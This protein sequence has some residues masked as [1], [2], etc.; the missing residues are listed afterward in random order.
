MMQS[1][2]SK[3]GVSSLSLAISFALA[4]TAISTQAFA[5]DD[6][7]AVKENVEKIAVVGSRAA[8][9][10]IGDSPV[11][12]DII[13]S[14]DLK[15]NGSTDMI[16]MLVTSVPSFNSRAQPISDAATLVR[17]VNLRGLPSDSTLILVNGKRRHRASVIAFQGGGINDGAQGPDI[18]VIPGVALKQ[19]EVL[20]D[21][22][23]AQYGSD[24]IAGVMNF[25]LK[26]D[27]D[28]GS[29]T[30]SQ[31]EYYEGDGA[32]TTI[33]GNIGLPLS[34]DGFVNIS[35]QYKTADATSRSVQRPD[36]AAL[37]AAGNEFIQDP[38]QTWGNPEIND[39]FTV[40]VNSGYDLNDNTKLYAFGNVSS[41][42]A[43]G[44][45]YYR[46]PHNRGNVYSNDGG[47]T[48]LV[49]DV[50]LAENGVASCSW[51]GNVP[52]N[53]DNVLDTPE[54]LAMVA[55]PNCFSMNQIRPGGYT[56]QFTGKIE[57]MSFFAGIKGESG[58]WMYDVS[59]GTGSNKASF[60]LKNSLNPSLGL[61]TPTDF[62]TGSYEQVET[63]FNV[64]MNR[65]V[66]IGGLED[67][68]FA[69]GFEWRE[70]SFEIG[71][72]DEASWIAG[73]YAEQGFNIGSHGFKGFG[74][75]SAGKN[76]RNN[77]GVYTDVEAY[78]TDEFLLGFALRYENFS[79]F[80][81]TLNYKLTA[82][83]MATDELSFRA[84]H[85]TGFRAPTVGQENVVNTQTSIVNGDLIQSFIAPPTD[86][87]AAF[88]GGETLNPEESVSYAA[89]FVYEYENLFLTVDYYNIEVT[90]R[91]AQSSQITVEESDYDALR[92]AGVEFPEL[93]SAVTYYTNDFDTT[94]QG[95]DIVGSYSMDLFSGDAKFSL[96]YGWTDTNVDKYDEATTDA[97]KVRRL[98]D[99][100]PAHRATL[101]WGQSWDDI[102]TSVRANYFGEYYATHADDT[103]DWGSEMA[104]SAVTVDLEV[105]YAL[106]DN[107]TVSVGANNIFDQEA[108]KLK[109]GTLGEL[110]AVYYESGPFDYN[111][112]FY[113]G[114][115]NYR[116]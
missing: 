16:D 18:S 40:F 85:S 44:G 8:P 87:L 43:T 97:G 90:G 31:G 34:D 32:A 67:I 77:I 47:E 42:E 37:S 49:G 53:V 99:G 68:S 78:L 86:P 14:D 103:S 73:P 76:K 112:G 12:V 33:D 93:I 66:T 111:G 65:F 115:V 107:L 25:V 80:G 28:G 59:A 106:M 82:Q 39:D 35:A 20:R 51:V 23:A 21:G 46:N 62:D 101:T 113:Y 79:T 109:D 11:P 5:A 2:K 1:K 96:A 55:D 98:E 83:Y 92:A 29:I 108:E 54:Y 64:D 45:F 114:R 91:I 58:E 52:A 4:G 89:G 94:T 72:G 26:D 9:R 84:S 10:S 69:T 13:S 7:A 6:E 61:A 70:E 100:I 56:P 88:Y 57:D 75:E 110:G 104:G 30:V 17:P 19:V 24:A 63:T 50:G 102:S 74:P 27:S 15:K 38:A 48:L 22:A 3:F 116:F 81:D 60:G 95:V 36:A 41:R 105:S 71:Q